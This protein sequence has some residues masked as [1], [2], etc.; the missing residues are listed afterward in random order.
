MVTAVVR[1]RP[2]ICA[3]IPSRSLYS[4]FAHARINILD[5]DVNSVCVCVCVC[6]CAWVRVCA[7]VHGCVCVSM[8]IQT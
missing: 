3:C 1:Q 7:C 8:Y 5:F 2:T 4:L 6:V